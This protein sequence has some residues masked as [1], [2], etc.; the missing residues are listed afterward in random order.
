M[1]K[2]KKMR[3]VVFSKYLNIDCILPSKP[4][5]LTECKTY[6][7]ACLSESVSSMYHVLYYSFSETFIF[8]FSEVTV[9]QLMVANRAL[10]TVI[11]KK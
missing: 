2:A 3:S 6:L 4:I 9:L 10:S 1:F 11:A 8:F 5:N 7:W